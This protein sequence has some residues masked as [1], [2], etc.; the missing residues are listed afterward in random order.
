MTTNINDKKYDWQEIALTN[1]TDW[2]IS[3]TIID[4]Q[5]ISLTTNITMTDSK[6]QWQISDCQQ[7]SKYQSIN[8][9]DWYI[10]L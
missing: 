3:L 5:P 7:I 8:I 2:Q 1:I 4:R 10:S 9:T 6:Y